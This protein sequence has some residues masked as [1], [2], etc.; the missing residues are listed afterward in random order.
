MKFF[1]ILAVS[2]FIS[3]FLFSCKK[4]PKEIWKVDIDTPKEKIEII[5]ISKDFYDSKIP[6]SEFKNKYGFFLSPGFDDNFYEKKRINP[7]EIQI[8][9]KSVTP[10]VVTKLQKELPELFA[11][12]KH[13]FPKFQNPK[14]YVFSSATAMYQE[15]VMYNAKQ[16]AMIIDLSSFLG[17]KSEYY[18]GIEDYF[19]S[20]MN[21]ENLLP[22]SSEAI[23]YAIVPYNKAEQKFLDEMV[24][25]GKV[26]I[27]QDAFLP[28]VPDYLKMGATAKQYEWSTNNEAD[29]WN[30]LVENDY[31]FSPDS[32]LIE[33]FISPGPFSKFYT[34]IDKESSPQI[35]VFVGWKIG[36]KFFEKKPDTKLE[37]FL[38]MSATEIF[39][40]SEYKPKN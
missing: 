2:A 25:S 32:R 11:R 30:Y 37:D 27:L 28:N 12:I 40:Q 35:G 21:P 5:D 39:N 26:M 38:K 22:K 3:L 13:Y 34:E 33:R 7:L 17:G 1:R 18:K 31:L 9:Q 24:Y 14:V 6:F 10:Q 4:E 23:A 8:Y 16:N 29:I 19:K 20:S 36:R 15:P